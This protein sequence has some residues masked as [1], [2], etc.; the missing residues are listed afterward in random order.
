M[1][2]Q[3]YL[4]T[5]VSK[6][7]YHSTGWTTRKIEHMPQGAK[8][9]LFST[10]LRLS[11]GPSSLLSKAHRRLLPREVSGRNVT[12]TT[13]LHIV[14]MLKMREVIRHRRNRLHGM[15]LNEAQAN[16]RWPYSEGKLIP[17]TISTIYC[18]HPVVLYDEV[19]RYEGRYES[20]GSYFFKENIIT[21]LMKCTYIM[22][23]FFT[24][25]RLFFH[26]VSS[27]INTLFHL[28]VRHCM[29]VA[30]NSLLKCRSSS[31]TLFEL[32]VFRKRRLQRASF[33]G[34]YTHTTR[35]TATM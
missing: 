17:S 10:A 13:H 16:Q 32:V 18:L 25:F 27:I 31:R 30:W 3:A 1:N 29:S 4:R 15:L 14:T 28:C 35:T 20:N 34:Q 7:S 2:H 21:I 33:R 12:L 8:I 26:K 19:V 9:S 11:R 6:Y 24:K 22:G 23:T 5:Y